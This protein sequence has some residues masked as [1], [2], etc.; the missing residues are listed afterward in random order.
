MFDNFNLFFLY[1]KLYLKFFEILFWIFFFFYEFI[2]ICLYIKRKY[3]CGVYMK[4]INLKKEI[5]YY[6]YLYVWCILYLNLKFLL[7]IKL[8][9]YIKMVVGFGLNKGNS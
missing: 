6:W 3:I 8:V 1:K 9:V 4:N 7:I 2:V 5:W